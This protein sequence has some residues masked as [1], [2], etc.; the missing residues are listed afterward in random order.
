MQGWNY[1]EQ[2]RHCGMQTR[3]EQGM[4]EK[5]QKITKH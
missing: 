1:D 4:K 2:E 3:P 5:R